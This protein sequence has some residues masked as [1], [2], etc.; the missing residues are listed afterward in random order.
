MGLQ[1]G[2]GSELQYPEDENIPQ[3]SFT[4]NFT[5]KID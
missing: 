1:F 4:S 5:Q 3:V 2:G